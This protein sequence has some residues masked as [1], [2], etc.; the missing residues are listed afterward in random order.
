MIPL[1]R[2]VP[3]MPRPAAPARWR[4]ALAGALALA[5]VTC[6]PMAA[7]ADQALG[8]MDVVSLRDSGR[9]IGGD[10]SIS[11]H[12][13]GRDWIFANEANRAAFEANPRAYAPG[14]G[15]NCPVKLSEGQKQPGRP[16]LAIVVSGTLYLTSTA[17]ARDRL[18]NDPAIIAV[19]AEQ[20]KRLGR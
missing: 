18:A 6:A 14:F 10:G 15:G 20:W 7:V 11:T 8:G 1:S 9:T 2:I 16:D 12:W 4:A 5:A 19:A 3:F 13:K 17:G